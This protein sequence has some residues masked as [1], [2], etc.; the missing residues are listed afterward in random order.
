MCR[1]VLLH[2]VSLDTAAGI[3]LDAVVCRP[4]PDS[5]G[6][7]AATAGTTYRPAASAGLTCHCCEFA[8][9]LAEFFSVGFIEIDLIFGAVD[10]E[11]DSLIRIGAVEIVL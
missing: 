3:N 11:G 8:E 4:E 5:P 10:S 1:G 9:S 6:V 7:S 2:Y